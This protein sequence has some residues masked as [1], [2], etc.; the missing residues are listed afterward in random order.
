MG[1]SQGRLAVVNGGS[2]LQAEN[3]K[4]MYYIAAIV[5]ILAIL[6]YM[7]M[8]KDHPE[9]PLGPGGLQPVPTGDV[10]EDEDDY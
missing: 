6:Y 2:P 5:V 3:N 4:M 1:A 8:K 7:K 10:Y 9:N